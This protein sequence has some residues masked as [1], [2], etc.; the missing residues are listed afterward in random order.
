[1]AQNVVVRLAPKTR[2]TAPRL[3]FGLKSVQIRPQEFSP[4]PRKGRTA[5]SFFAERGGDVEAMP[6]E[7]SRLEVVMGRKDVTQLFGV[8][9]RQGEYS[10]RDEFRMTASETFLVPDRPLDIPD[11][12]KDTIDFAYIPRPIEFYGPSLRPPSEGVPHLHLEAVGVALNALRAH[13]QKW[14]GAG[15]KVAMVE[16]FLPASLLCRQWLQAH[17]VSRARHRQAG[18]R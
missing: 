16:R 10:S 17:T 6:T 11:A 15:V 13:R 3:E 18:G 7:K 5:L 4:D 12:L 14:T 1:M 8:D 9:F 2:S